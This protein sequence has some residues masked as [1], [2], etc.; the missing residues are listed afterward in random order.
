MDMQDSEPITLYRGIE[1]CR[2]LVKWFFRF[3]DIVHIRLHVI[4]SSDHGNVEAKG[5]GRPAEGVIADLRG[6]RVRI[7]SDE[8]LRSTVKD[9]FPES[10]MWPTFGLPED[11]FPLLAPERLA[12]VP[13]GQ[14]TVAHGGITIE[15]LIV[16]LIQIE[17]KI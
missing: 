5:C 12:F 6:E 2:C 11:Y 3:N 13:K 16:P 1:V 14:K 7:Y 15:E 8:L 4:L 9:K 10:I 17:R